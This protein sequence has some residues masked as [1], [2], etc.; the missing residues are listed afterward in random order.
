MFYV[1]LNSLS[2]LDLVEL[3]RLADGI[4][5]TCRI[6]DT[7]C[8]DLGTT[9]FVQEAR[10]LVKRLDSPHVSITVIE[11]IELKQKGFGGIYSVGKGATRPPA[12]VILSYLP[13]NADKTLALVG[14]GIV[15]G[16]FIL[17]T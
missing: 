11:G 17:L 5:Q 10:D 9:T 15:Y 6:M 4:R 2:T 13:A 14:K 12:L 1:L 7:P 3:Q 16:N 8:E